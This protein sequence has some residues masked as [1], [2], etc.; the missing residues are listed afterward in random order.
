LGAFDRLLK[1]DIKYRITFSIS[2]TLISL[3]TD[4][5]LKKRYISY[6]DKL[7]ELSKKE[8]KRTAREDEPYHELAKYYHSWYKETK[9]LYNDR[10]KTDLCAAFLE[11]AKEGRLELITTAA[12]HGYL[13]LLKNQ[14]SA[15]RSQVFTGVKTFETA[16]GFTPKGFW[17]PE[18]GYYPGLENILQEAG[19]KYFFIDTHGLTNADKTSPY[20]VYAPISCTNG[21]HAF[22]RDPETSRCVWSAAEGYPG[23]FIGNIIAT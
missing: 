18:C 2:P 6:L 15:V 8:V 21:L 22:A 14:E 3:L 9:K 19:V 12:T 17:L 5:L 4:D 1:E 10:Y 11:L 20:G 23:D 13:P 16:F 7:I